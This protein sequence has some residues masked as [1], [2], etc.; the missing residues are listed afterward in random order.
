MFSA[1][2][3]D[4]VNALFEAFGAWAVWGNVARLKRDRDVKGVVWQYTIVYWIWGMWNVLYYPWLGQWFSGAAGLVLVAGN[5]RWLL[6]WSA[7][8]R[9][10]IVVIDI[11]PLPCGCLVICTNR[12]EHT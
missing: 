8:R 1:H 11:D 5:L 10:Q 6:L 4:I 12:L 7:I 3:P 9:H 2:W